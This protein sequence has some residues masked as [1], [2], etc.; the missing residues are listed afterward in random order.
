MAFESYGNNLSSAEL[1]EIEEKTEDCVSKMS[2][3]EKSRLLNEL[4]RFAIDHGVSI[5]ELKDPAVVSALLTGV[6]EGFGKWLSSNWYSVV[7]KLSRYLK[8]GSLIT[9]VG[10]L[11]GYYMMDMDTMSGV[12][13]AAAA[14]IIA[15]VVSALKGLK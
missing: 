3:D 2:D 7:D 14:Y 12:K 8:L 4:E 11:I 15:N 1:K 10:S 5:E 6:K 9:F 13:V